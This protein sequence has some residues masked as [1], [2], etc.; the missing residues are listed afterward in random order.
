MGHEELEQRD[1]DAPRPLKLGKSVTVER[2]FVVI[3]VG[4]G[5]EYRILRA[6]QRDG[7]VSFRRKYLRVGPEKSHRE[8]HA[9]RQSLPDERS[10]ADEIVPRW[11]QNGHF[12]HERLHDNR[13]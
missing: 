7:D 1:E 13:P 3:C 11:V 9:L 8:Q 2:K 10:D 12:Y 6:G 5:E 4:T